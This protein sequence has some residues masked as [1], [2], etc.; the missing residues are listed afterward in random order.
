MID[1]DQRH[2]EAYVRE[3]FGPGAKLLDF[4]DIGSLDKQ[5]IKKFGYGKPL[6]LRIEVDGQQREG[7]L[8]VMKGDKYGH[9]YYWD[10]AAILMFQY[11]TSG[12]LP[13]HVK[14]L[15]L[16]YVDAAGS[17]RPLRGPREFFILNEKIEGYDYYHDIVR[18]QQG[19]FRPEDLDMARSFARWLATIHVQKKDDPDLYYRRVRNLLG[20][21]ECIMG[22]VDEA[23]VHPYELFTD[24]RFLALEKR[25][26]DWRWRL[27]GY[28]HRLS[29]VH[30]DFHP[31]NVMVRAPMD[32]TVLDRSRGEWG[33]PGGDVACMALN[34]LLFGILGQ[35][36]EPVRFQGPFRELHDAFFEA[37]LEATGDTE[38]FEVMAPF[39][40]FRCL[41]VASPEWYPD[42]SPAVRKALLGFME[43]VLEDETFDYRNVER[44]LEGL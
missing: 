36:Q 17:L 27:K 44:Y 13:G 30:G 11:E 9:Q 19:D 41:V 1:L 10:R 25:L 24:S 18:I 31:W 6:L 35:E 12:L 42:H 3:A 7:V 4:G 21:S 33:E 15:G 5:G 29:A 2:L 43:R 28:T 23:F 14:P 8:S 37:Y 22:L 38:I 40:V 34:Y 26:L 20:S 16:G 32:F 39:Y